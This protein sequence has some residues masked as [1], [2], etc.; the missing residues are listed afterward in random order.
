MPT[1]NNRSISDLEIYHAAN[2]VIEQF[3]GDAVIA[4]ASMIDW[5]LDH[6]DAEG[7]VVWMRIRSAIVALQSPPP[8]D[9]KH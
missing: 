1:R 2:L 5:M 4:A 8:S 3:R 7:R 6:G 9:A